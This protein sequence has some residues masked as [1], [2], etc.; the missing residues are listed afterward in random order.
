MNTKPIENELL[1]TRSTCKDL[2]AGFNNQ[3]ESTLMR[4]QKLELVT[5]YVEALVTYKYYLL[6][7]ISL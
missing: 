7:S 4:A 3:C 1:E 5:H 2:F 6:P